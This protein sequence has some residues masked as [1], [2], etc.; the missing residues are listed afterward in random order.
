MIFFE[1]LEHELKLFFGKDQQ[2]AIKHFEGPALTLAVPGSGKTTLMLARAVYLSEVHGLD[3]RSLLNLTFSKAAA[4]DMVERYATRFR[5][6]FRHQFE[7]S[8]IHS[9]AYKVL[10]Q[11]WKERSIR[12]RRL[13]A[14]TRELLSAAAY[15]VSSSRLNDDQFEALSNQIGYARN[16]MYAAGQLSSNG[17]D[18]PERIRVSERNA[19]KVFRSAG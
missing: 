7:F 11:V 2:D 8:T 16:M 1:T 10:G 4:S 14:N 3:P 6:H 19:A 9:F 18:F 15:Q 5:P 17:L 12:P 13:L